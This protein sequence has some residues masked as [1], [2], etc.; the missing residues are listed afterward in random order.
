MS[1]GIVFFNFGGGCVVRLL[2]A[3]HSLREWHSGPVTVMLAE[4]DEFCEKAACDIQRYADIQ[5]FALDSVVKRNVKSAIKPGLFQQS[6]YDATLMLDGDLIFCADP[7][8]LLDTL[9]EERPFGVTAFSGWHCDGPRMRKRVLRCADWLWPSDRHL[10][11]CEEPG[12]KHPAINIGVIGWHKAGTGVMADWEWMTNNIAGQHIADEVA[13]QVVFH[14][15]PT[16]VW[17]PRWNASCVYADTL[18][19]GVTGAHILHYHGNKHTAPDREAS[20]LWLCHLARR[21]DAGDWTHA[22]EYLRWPDK[23]LKAAL[24]TDKNLLSKAL[25]WGT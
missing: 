13:C 24:K 3:L 11:L 9:T 4:G 23:A 1:R 22:D 18:E 8:T 21:I 19:G 5:W 17:G 15:H 12:K 16:S 20:R 25:E 6:P 14:R 10:I 7:G 2:V